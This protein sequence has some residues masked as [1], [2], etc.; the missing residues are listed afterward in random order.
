MHA[1]APHSIAAANAH[2]AAVLAQAL[3]PPAGGDR[4]RH[5]VAAPGSR[6]TPLLLA[7]AAR[8]EVRLHMVLDE[9]AAGF[10]ALGLA[11]ITGRASILCCTS[12]SAG[13]H[14]LPAIVEASLAQVPLVVLTADRPPELQQCG[15]PQTMTQANLFGPHVRQAMTL[16]VPEPQALGVIAGAWRVQGARA[17]AAAEQQARGPVHLNVPFR[18]PLWAKPRAGQLPQGASLALSSVRISTAEP[19]LDATSAQALAALC[20]QAT[21]GLLVVGPLSPDACG[22]EDAQAIVALARAFGWPCVVDGCSQLR[23]A[24]KGASDDD[25]RLMTT[26]DTLMRLPA[27]VSGLDYPDVIVRFGQLPTSKPL[28]RWLGQM[29]T[30]PQTTTVLVDA[31]GQWIDPAYVGD[32]LLI[33]RPRPLCAQVLAQLATAGQMRLDAAW[34]SVWQRG[35]SAA[36]RAMTRALGA[37]EP[38]D[39][40]LTEAFVAYSLS[41]ALPPSALLHVASSMPIRDWDSYGQAGSAL[42]DLA[43]CRHGGPRISCSRGVN[44][45]DGTVATLLGLALAWSEGPT[46]GVMGDLAF[47]HDVQ[48]LQ[49]AR[50]LQVPAV[51]IVLNNGGGDIFAQL[52]IAA[53]EADDLP[54]LQQSPSAPF[55]A[56][57][58]TPQKADMQALCRAAHLDVRQVRSRAQWQQALR[59]CVIAARQ[60]GFESQAGLQVI[61]VVID[62]E[63]SR[64]ARTIVHEAVARSLSAGAD[65]S[66]RDG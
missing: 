25:A 9:R 61:E 36:L 42:G 12:G 66:R 54:K 44:G 3:T 41:Q 63:V 15:A 47:L 29:G 31:H 49:L 65:P 45:I 10:V 62:A 35:Q 56:Y 6:H 27:F 38:A 26:A 17:L 51:A 8:P 48:S 18:E 59:A 4:P 37:L 30:S 2:A 34:A 39:A 16:A 43:P 57:F 50:Q 24:A 46:V 58:R 23:F 5:V 21:R 19:S 60:Q 53:L 40:P 33:A 32:W 7:L 22:V 20:A 1:D 14:F 52:P 11:K 28:C 64:R 13:A 55:D